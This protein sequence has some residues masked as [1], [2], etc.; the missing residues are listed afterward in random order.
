MQELTDKAKERLEKYLENVRINLVSSGA[1]ADE[2]IEDLRR[3]ID[4]ETTAAK[5]QIVTKEDIERVISNLRIAEPETETPQ[6]KSNCSSGK[7]DKFRWTTKFSRSSFVLTIIF[8]VALP[9]V[10]ILTE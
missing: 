6:K 4:E 2:V 1:D 9:I 3:H 10:T 5:L 7:S 8:G